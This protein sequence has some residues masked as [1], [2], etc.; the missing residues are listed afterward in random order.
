ME[1]GRH[2]CACVVHMCEYVC[3]HA[4]LCLKLF[5]EAADV[6]WVCMYVSEKTAHRSNVCIMLV[7]KLCIVI[8]YAR[9]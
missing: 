2:D 1:R 9:C 3:L 6:R 7:R 8:T 5:T 4:G